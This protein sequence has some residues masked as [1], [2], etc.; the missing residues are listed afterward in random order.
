MVGVGG[1][2]PLGRTKQ[3]K[4]RICGAFLFVRESGENHCSTNFYHSKNLHSSQRELP[5]G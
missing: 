3:I 4:P 1:S 2:S 5:E